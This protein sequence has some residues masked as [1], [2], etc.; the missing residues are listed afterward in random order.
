MITA[1]SSARAVRGTSA[2][3]AENMVFL[4][5]NTTGTGRPI[6][7]TWI[8]SDGITPNYSTWYN[9]SVDGVA[10]SWGAYIPTALASGV[11]RVESRDVSTASLTACPG[12]SA[13]GVWTGAGNTV[14]PTAGTTPIVFSTDD[15][16]FANQTF[17]ADTDADT[18]GDLAVTSV[19]CSTPSGY[20]SNS[21][22][23]NDANAAINPGATE[24]CNGIDDDCDGLTDEGVA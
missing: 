4:Y 14:N 15:A 17:Y 9:P 24:V 13:S 1:A 5:D 3:T 7:G 23:C 8:E 10:G 19:A 22:D 12:T 11:Q 16:S 21:T 18:Y 2:G 6:Y 20:V